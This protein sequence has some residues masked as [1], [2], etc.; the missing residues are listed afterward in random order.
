M[1]YTNIWNSLFG[2]RFINLGI[3]GDCAGNVLWR[4]RDIPFLPSLRDI[5]ILC[6]TD[7]I[8][9]DSS[10]DITQGL[11]AVGSVFKTLSSSPNIFICEILP[12]YESFSINRL[13]IN[14]VND[15]LKSKCL[16]KSFDFINQ[17]NGWTLKF[18]GFVT[19]FR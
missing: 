8:T 7:N 10:Y 1:R 2:N 13:I 12:R 4:A 15:L 5:V 14:E 11:T 3:S 17:N 16:V 9:K 18:W 6:G 19:F